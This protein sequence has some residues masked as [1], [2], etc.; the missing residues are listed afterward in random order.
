MKYLIAIGIIIAFIFVYMIISAVAGTIMAKRS[1]KLGRQEREQER[2]RL[3]LATRNSYPHRIYNAVRECSD[4]L[5]MPTHRVLNLNEPIVGEPLKPHGGNA[6]IAS[7]TTI[8]GNLQLVARQLCHA[9]A[10][11]LAGRFEAANASLDSIETSLTE[12]LRQKNLRQFEAAAVVET[13]E[14]LR[15]A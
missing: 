8:T 10:C 9:R 3:D 13:Q 2:I 15:A 11:F 12:I 14:N 4:F 1:E 5:T 6:L 7:N